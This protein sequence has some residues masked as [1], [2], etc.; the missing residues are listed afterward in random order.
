MSDTPDIKVSDTKVVN[1]QPAVEAF[2]LFE[3]AGTTYGIPSRAI[4]RIE[5]VE[6]LTPVPRAQPFLAGVVW[7]R[8]QVI[9]AMDLRARFGLPRFDNG[10][11]KRL[12]V[13]NCEGRTVGLIVDSAREFVKL[14]AGAVQPPPAPIGGLSGE[15]LQGIATLG[16]RMVIILDV[17]AVLQQPEPAAPEATVETEHGGG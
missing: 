9:P 12:I 6:N 14:P 10:A 8:G 2:V 7:I 5:M 13:V 4:Q 17:A 3:L 1:A 11:R 16:N 15:Y